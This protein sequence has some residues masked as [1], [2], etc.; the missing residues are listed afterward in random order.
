[1]NNRQKPVSVIQATKRLAWKHHSRLTVWHWLN[2]LLTHCLNAVIQQESLHGS[3]VCLDQNENL[4][5]SSSTLWHYIVKMTRRKAPAVKS[6][7]HTII[8]KKYI[9]YPVKWHLI[10]NIHHCW[11]TSTQSVQCLHQ[12]NI[13]M[14]RQIKS[15]IAGWKVMHCEWETKYQNDCIKSSK[16]KSIGFHNVCYI[17][18]WADKYIIV[19]K[20]NLQNYHVNYPHQPKILT[21]LS[22]TLHNFDANSFKIFLKSQLLENIMQN[23]LMRFFQLKVPMCYISQHCTN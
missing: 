21:C 11:K 7:H 18:L 12:P 22:E 3:V 15:V 4:L 19:S 1:M 16:K 20:T 10:F 17:W 9:F 5:K 13:A 14:Q 2:H 6:N 23:V 8:T